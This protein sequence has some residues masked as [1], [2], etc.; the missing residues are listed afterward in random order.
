MLLAGIISNLLNG[1]NLKVHN[2][3]I[4]VN[5]AFSLVYD[6]NNSPVHVFTL[7]M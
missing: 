4:F 1:R 7:K 2:V 5:S 6:N 3:Q